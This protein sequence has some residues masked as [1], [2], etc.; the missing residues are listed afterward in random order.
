MAAILEK[1]GVGTVIPVALNAVG[2]DADLE[3]ALRI[4]AV[5]DFL[6]LSASR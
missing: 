3:L 4:L 1:T 6:A 2:I 5:I